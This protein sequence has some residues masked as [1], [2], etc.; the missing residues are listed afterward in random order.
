MTATG[1]DRPDLRLRQLSPPRPPRR[2][3]HLVVVVLLATLLLAVAGA[4]LLGYEYGSSR[5]G[6]HRAAPSPSPSPSTATGQFSATPASATT[7]MPP[8]QPRVLTLITK[9]LAYLAPGQAGTQPRFVVRPDERLRMQVDNKD[10]YKHS[11]TFAPSTVDLDAR[12]HTVSVTR[13]FRSPTKPGTYT[14]YCKYRYIGM[15]GRIIVRRS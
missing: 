9:H 15:D 14:F 3:P 4:V 11:F 1:P 13:P 12:E 10:A 6:N 8:P 2:R 7:T 5:N